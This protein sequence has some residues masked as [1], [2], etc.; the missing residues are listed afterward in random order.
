MS[1]SSVAQTSNP[2]EIQD[3][4][5]NTTRS[6]RT[7]FSTDLLRMEKESDINNI[8]SIIGSWLSD[9]GK[10][11]KIRERYAYIIFGL[12]GAQIISVN[13]MM[14]FIGLGS[15]KFT[16]NIFYWFLTIV[17]SE[18][19]GF[20]YVVANYLFKPNDQMLEQFIKLLKNHQ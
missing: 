14:F 19:I 17:V 11:A 13:I 5:I 2:V 15:L 4:I 1:G 7:S 16:D 12:L 9:Q 8:N 6:E 10:N 18:I 3:L 20:V